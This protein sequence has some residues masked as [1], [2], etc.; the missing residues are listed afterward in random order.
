MNLHIAT[1]ADDSITRDCKLKVVGK[2]KKASVIIRPGLITRVV[3]PDT[4]MEG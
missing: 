4:P 1:V 2:V 3:F